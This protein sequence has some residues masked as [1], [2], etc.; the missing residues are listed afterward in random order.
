M[1]KKHVIA[2]I[3]AVTFG[4]LTYAYLSIGRSLCYYAGDSEYQQGQQY[5]QELRD[6]CYDEATKKIIVGV[7]IMALL[8][9]GVVILSSVAIKKLKSKG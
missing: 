8:G 2:V 4:F 9:H 5:P 1:S 3:F 6:A 7:L